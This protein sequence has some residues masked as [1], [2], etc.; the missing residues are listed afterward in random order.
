[1]SDE[2][3]THFPAPPGT[4]DPRVAVVGAGWAGLSAA[5]AL[6]EAGVDIA[7]FESAPMA[8]GRA[9]TV[10]LA[11]PLGRFDV[12]N[13]QHLI[14]G[15]YRAALALVARLAAPTSPG[16]R[17]GGSPNERAGDDARRA[18]LPAARLERAPLALHSTSGLRL[19][20]GPSPRAPASAHAR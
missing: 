19:Q 3:R 14:V 18:A 15:A 7:L 17:A 16:E 9:R 10:S 12:D 11:T 13:G 8:G 4:P 2:R 20:A 1:M 5:L 6:A